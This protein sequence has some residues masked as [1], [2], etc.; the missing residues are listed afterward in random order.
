[1]GQVGHPV[2]LLLIKDG[3]NRTKI[4][5]LNCYASILFGLLALA[6]KNSLM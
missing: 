1:M 4:I 6:N 2:Y 5:R 3:S